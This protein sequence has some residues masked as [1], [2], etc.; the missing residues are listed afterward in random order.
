LVDEYKRQYERPTD[1]ELRP[2]SSLSRERERA[3]RGPRIPP[4]VLVGVVLVGIVV[5]LWFVGSRNNNSSNNPTTPNTSAAQPQHTRAHHKKQ[6]KTTPAKPKT[7]TLQ[8]V[9]TGQVYVCLV[10]GSGAK[11]IPGRIFAA[12][13]TI[14]TEKAAKM[15]LTLGNAAVEMKVNGKT[16]HV[17]PASSSIGYSI[18]PSGMTS[19]PVSQQPRCT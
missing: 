7:V 15:Q 4:W 10:N 16:V 2:I 8:L 13:Q 18:T 3:A 12:G 1:H 5:A 9:P 11:L 17:S 14:P 6:H 19:L